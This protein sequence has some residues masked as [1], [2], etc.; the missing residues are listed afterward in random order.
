MG[1]GAERVNVLVRFLVCLDLILFARL[2]IRIL[3]RLTVCLQPRQLKSLA[4][5]LRRGAGLRPQ[6]GGCRALPPY[7]YSTVLA[8][9]SPSLAVGGRRP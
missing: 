5:Q 4:L 7:L 1:A 2:T 9:S 6:A 3:D 8:T